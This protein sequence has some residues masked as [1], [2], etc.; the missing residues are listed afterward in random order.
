MRAEYGRPSART[1]A[2][3]LQDTDYKR[4]Y[5]CLLTMAPEEPETRYIGAVLQADSFVSG[6]SGMYQPL[7]FTLKQMLPTASESHLVQLEDEA[8]EGAQR[9]AGDWLADYDP[10][11]R[12]ARA[13]LQAE[14]NCLL[15]PL[16]THV[17]LVRNIFERLDMEI[18][19]IRR[20]AVKGSPLIRPL[21]QR[22]SSPIPA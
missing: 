10:G 12:G 2:P 21:N 9:L 19:K 22:I 6:E 18:D 4:Y 5:D 1:D 17:T 13:I 20:L 8:I 15:L 16:Q 3:L 14:D 11:N 7:L